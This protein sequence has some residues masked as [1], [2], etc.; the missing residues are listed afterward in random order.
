VLNPI[1]AAL[2]ELI[3]IQQQLIEFAE[4]KRVILIERKVDELNLLVKQEAK[5]VKQLNH[6]ENER[7]RLTGELLQ[8]HPALSFNQVIGQLPDKAIKNKLQSQMDQ[9]QDLLSEL[10]A[11]NKVNERLLIDSMNFVQHMIEQV[12]KSK[13]QHF[14]YQSPLGQQTSQSSSRGFFDTKA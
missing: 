6:A 8:Q 4:K 11:K 7:E 5:L 12:T 3:H 14:N 9:L 10:Q 13:Q 2:D 1:V